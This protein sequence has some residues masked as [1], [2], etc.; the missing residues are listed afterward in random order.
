MKIMLTFLWIIS[1]TPRILV[2][3]SIDKFFI[4]SSSLKKFS[5]VTLLNTLLTVLKRSW[6]MGTDYSLIQFLGSILN[7]FLTTVFLSS[8]FNSES[9]RFSLSGFHTSYSG[10]STVVVWVSL[11]ASA[12]ANEMMEWDHDVSA[13][14]SF[15]FVLTANF[16]R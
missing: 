12:S 14:N 10:S 7:C 15:N 5:G 6:N 13:Y 9:A 1:T 8:W 3:V 4:V 2:C 11:L 16:R